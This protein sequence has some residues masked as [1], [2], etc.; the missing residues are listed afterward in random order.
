MS[1]NNTDTA[2]EQKSSVRFVDITDEEAGQRIDNFLIT[3]LKGVPKS[4]VYRILRKGEVRVNKGRIKPTYRL[5]AGDQVRIPPVRIDEKPPAPK[6]GQA[7][8]EQLEASILFEDKGLIIF[9]KRSGLAVHGGSGLSFGLIEALRASRPT[10]PYLELVHRLDRDTSGLLLVAKKRSYLRHL[11]EQLR[12]DG[13]VRKHYRALVCGH[14]DLGKHHENAPLYKNTMTSGERMVRVDENKGKQAHTLFKPI[15]RFGAASYMEIE[16]FTGRTHQIRV[17]AAHAGHP[18]AG[19]DKYGLQDCN[20][21]LK[22]YGL[23]RLFLHAYRLEFTH[24]GTEQ[25]MDIIA[26]LDNKLVAVLDALESK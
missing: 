3:K 19:D 23:K 9:N 4:R 2:H 5:K 22:K 20:R 26:P 18:V 17:H 14:W 10:A 8:M 12:T 11:H 1:T 13:G 7:Q 21:D 15:S 6:P 25:A 24:P 16:L